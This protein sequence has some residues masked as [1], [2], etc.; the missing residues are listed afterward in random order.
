MTVPPLE[1]WVEGGKG[2]LI[3]R[4]LEVLAN[5]FVPE[6]GGPW[7]GGVPKK[8]KKRE[9]GTNMRQLKEFELTSR[10]VHSQVGTDKLKTCKKKVG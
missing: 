4:N 2:L 3:A 9:W 10:G 8:R 5:R 6:R 1:R 7:V